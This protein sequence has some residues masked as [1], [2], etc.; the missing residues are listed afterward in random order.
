MKREDL[1]VV[2]Q[3]AI[4]DVAANAGQLLI[5]MLETS[6]DELAYINLNRCAGLLDMNTTAVKRF[7]GEYLIDFGP[8]NKRVSLADLKR[9]IAARRAKMEKARKKADDGNQLGLS[10]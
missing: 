7:L 5:N 4:K 8:R 9:A 1:P 6:L 3:E 10:L 2:A